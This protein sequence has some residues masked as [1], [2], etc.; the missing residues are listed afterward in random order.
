M[1]KTRTDGG[2]FFGIWFCWKTEGNEKQQK[3]KAYDLMQCDQKT[4]TYGNFSFLF[5]WN[6]VLLKN[7]SRSRVLVLLETNGKGNGRESR[8]QKFGSKVAAPSP[9]FGRDSESTRR[10]RSS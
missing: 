1:T 10:T 6:L 2:F 5:F 3:G 9:I 7:R 4:R 8:V